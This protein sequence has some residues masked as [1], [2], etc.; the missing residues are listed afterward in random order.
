MDGEKLLVKGPTYVRKPLH[1]N[2]RLQQHTIALFIPSIKFLVAIC[3]NVIAI[4]I[5]NAY[6][7]KLHP[8]KFV[9]YTHN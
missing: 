8:S 4:I 7:R 9:I 3:E 2:P 5:K 6:L 1:P